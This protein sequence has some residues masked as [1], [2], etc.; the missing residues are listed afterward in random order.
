MTEIVSSVELVQIDDLPLLTTF[1]PTG[2][3]PLSYDASP[4]RY[5]LSDLKNEFLNSPTLFGSPKSSTP[6]AGD[7]S[8]RIAT[9]AFVQGELS[10]LGLNEATD[11]AFGTVRTNQTAAVPVVYLKTEIDNYRASTIQPVNL[12]GTGASNASTA[13]SNI[14][15]AKSGL[16]SD[17]TALT[18]LT[19]VPSVV[20]NIL[21]AVFP[22][23][24]FIGYAGDVLPSSNFLFCHGQ[25]ISRTTYATLF[26]RIGTT[27]G[28]GDGSTTFNLPDYRG[29]V[30]IGAGTE[31]VEGGVYVRGQK[32]GEKDHALIE[33]ELATHGH[34]NAVTS[35]DGSHN[36]TA[37]TSTA[38]NHA[39]TG[40][41]SGSSFALAR[42]FGSNSQTPNNGGFDR[43]VSATLDAN[44][45]HPF[46]TNAAGGHTHF[47]TTTTQTGHTHTISIPE[48]GDGEP[49]NNIQPC[50]AENVIIRVL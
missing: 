23:G 35:N 27:H 20:Q 16:N 14:G 41:T 40:N 37:T 4:Y 30:L 13:L 10:G 48:T 18:A 11:S 33:A 31:Q 12:G 32:Y 21:N 36:H 17:I 28:A 50:V 5:S 8:T 25:A 45:T 46:T 38:G 2:F 15:A 19:S 42:N 1:Q 34:G 39:H 47:L 29:R 24:S 22:I 7:N 43:L 6:N 9:T 26:S 49:H 44:H 3:I